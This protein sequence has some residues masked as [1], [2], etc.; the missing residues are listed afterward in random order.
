M[1]VS[2][3]IMRLAVIGNLLLLVTPVIKNL[4]FKTRVEKKFYVIL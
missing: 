3:G 1:S 2:F 4:I